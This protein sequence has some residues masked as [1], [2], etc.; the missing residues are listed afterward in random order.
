M[1][2]IPEHVRRM[3]D[4]PP[5]VFLFEGR[6]PERHSEIGWKLT[7]IPVPHEFIYVNNDGEIVESS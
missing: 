3:W 2:E 5:F 7:D 4:Y 1:R 6:E